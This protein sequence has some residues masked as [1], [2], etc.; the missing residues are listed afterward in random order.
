MARLHFGAAGSAH[1]KAAKALLQ[2]GAK[3][4]SAEG[5]H[6]GWNFLHLARTDTSF[7][8]RV[9][10]KCGLVLPPVVTEAFSSDWEIGFAF[11]PIRS[12]LC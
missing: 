3:R 5:S 6:G 9:V 10:R 1:V 2:A 4:T 12:H 11:L 7:E 8:L